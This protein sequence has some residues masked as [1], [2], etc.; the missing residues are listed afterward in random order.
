VKPP[1]TA[2][3]EVTVKVSVVAPPV[4]S[5]TV[6]LS[7]VKIEVSSLVIVPVPTAPVVMAAA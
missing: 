3:L 4:P 7:M 1:C 6:G 2:A 5:V